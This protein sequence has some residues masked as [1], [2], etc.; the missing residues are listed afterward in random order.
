MPRIKSTPIPLHVRM[1]AE[2]RLKWQ[3]T[4]AAFQT[5]PN[6]A[7][8][9]HRALATI[10]AGAQQLAVDLKAADTPEGFQAI[11]ERA[12]GELWEVANRCVFKDPLGVLF[13]TDIANYCTLASSILAKQVV[14]D[15]DQDPEWRFW[16]YQ[17]HEC[18]RAF[19]RAMF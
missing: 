3:A 15:A 8:R 17:A 12:K 11:A 4:R 18:T 7:N 9:D 19:Q 13:L 6:L 10:V 5:T 1:D 2:R 16:Q 14:E